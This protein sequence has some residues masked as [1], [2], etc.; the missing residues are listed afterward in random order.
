MV[1]ILARIQASGPTRWH[2]TIWL[3]PAS[4]FNSFALIVQEP[5]TELYSLLRVLNASEKTENKFV[6]SKEKGLLLR[7]AA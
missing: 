7:A 1:L 3:F 2:T 5:L 4:K 6:I